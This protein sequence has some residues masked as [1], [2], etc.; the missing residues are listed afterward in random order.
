ML[1]SILLVILC[2]L[3]SLDLWRQYALNDMDY[4]FSKYVDGVKV[5][6]DSWKLGFR[7]ED[8]EIKIDDQKKILDQVTWHTFAT[9]WH[10]VFR[11]EKHDFMSTRRSRL[12]IHSLIHNESAIFEIGCGSEGPL[13]RIGVNDFRGDSRDECQIFAGGAS[14]I[15]GANTMFEV[16]HLEEELIA[17]RSISND[18]FLRA[19]PP[20][21]DN[22]DLPWKLMIGGPLAGSAERF[23][24]TSDGYLYSPL[25]GTNDNLQFFL[26]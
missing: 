24:V 2:V 15:S 22:P 3:A 10:S 17:L 11:N 19:V 13:L 5:S 8:L 20:P 9:P 25:L 6:S 16:I 12:I 14:T 1:M 18:L 7:L 4:W 23:R 21:A 26:I